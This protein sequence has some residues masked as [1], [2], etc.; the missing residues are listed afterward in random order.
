MRCSS[1][2]WLSTWASWARPADDR[3]RT[4]DRCVVA[5]TVAT[6]QSYFYAR[7]PF[8]THNPLTSVSLPRVEIRLTEQTL[9]SPFSLCFS[10][11]PCLCYTPLSLALNDV[12]F[13]PPSPLRSG[14]RS[15][16]LDQPEV[17]TIAVGLKMATILEGKV[18]NRKV[19]T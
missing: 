7:A 16:Y 3:R 4:H 13:S 18:A 9:S 8:L 11:C 19:L 12:L 10:L 6:C 5:T 14:L 1:C 2:G 17:F 15:M